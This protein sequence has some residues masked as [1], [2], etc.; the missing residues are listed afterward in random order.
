[1]RKFL[2]W[3]YLSHSFIDFSSLGFVQNANHDYNVFTQADPVLRVRVA[4]ATAATVSLSIDTGAPDHYTL[5]MELACVDGDTMYIP[6]GDALRDVYRHELDALLTAPQ[7]LCLV[8]S[9]TAALLDSDGVEINHA[10]MTW[11]VYEAVGCQLMGHDAFLTCLPDR[12]RALVG[13]PNP[14]TVPVPTFDVDMTR[15][16]VGGATSQQSLVGSGGSVSFMI[17]PNNR[18]ASVRLY[19]S[20]GDV[21]VS[22][23]FDWQGCSDDKMLVAWWSPELG[24]WKSQCA[25]VLSETAEAVT[26]RD[27]YAGFGMR[28]GTAA[29]FAASLRFP[30]CSQRD[31]AF[32]RDLMASGAVFVRR[33]VSSYSG[34][35]WSG[36]GEW[37]S[38]RV[39]GEV[40]AVHVGGQ[41][42]NFDF[43][44]ITN[45]T[46]EL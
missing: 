24:G 6:V 29:N 16:F 34:S 7:P 26:R 39:R 31:V 37:L 46:D 27:V 10:D 28:T 30:M 43:E 3:E 17:N 11:R 42:R 12:W 23:L 9:V 41:S 25:D 5:L 32:L 1:M 35:G 45:T 15:N 19:N 21:E 2:T 20:D 14:V 18:V 38:V 22:T 33:S 4:D 13:V 40:P 44:V 8:C 36:S